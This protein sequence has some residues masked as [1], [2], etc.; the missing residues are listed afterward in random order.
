MRRL[1]ALSLLLSILL[2]LLAGCA[3]QE[4]EEYV[5]TGDAILM[6]NEEVT[7]A[8]DALEDETLVLA[9]Y[10]TRSMNPLIAMNFSNRVLFSLIYQGLFAYNSQNQTVPILCS[11]YRVSPDN[12]IYTFYVDPAATFSDGT[13]VTIGDVIASYD[14]ARES[15]YYKG[16]FTHIIEYK[17]REDGGLT[18]YLDTPYENLP[19][20]L[21][22][23][24]VKASEVASEHPLGTGPYEFHAGEDGADMT[25]VEHWWCNDKKVK[26]STRAKTIKVIEATSQSQ[27]RDEFEFG[28]LNLACADP[29]LDS[30]GEYRCDFELWE[31]DNGVMVYLAVNTLYSDYF[32]DSDVLRKA[33]TYAIDREGINE[34]NYRGMGQPS[35][36]ITSP[37]SPYYN[38]DLAK[39]YEY[40]PMRFL[41]AISSLKI[42]KNDK[43][44]VKKLRILVNADD[45]AR[46]RTARQIANHLTE[47]GIPAGVLEYGSTGGV[48]YRQIINAGN[49]D[50]YLGQTRLP[51]NYD[52]SEFFKGYGNLANRCLTNE[53]LLNMAQESLSNSGNFY[54]LN[55]MVA[56]DGS[57]I[58]ILF[59]TYNIYS[60]RGELLDLNPARDNVFYYT[61]GKTMDSILEESQTNE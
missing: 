43:N 33:L 40:D 27:L 49:Y 28:D 52:V 51:P 58:P 14:A 4:E 38:A 35:T 42:P 50:L 25:R 57:V 41:D 6:E 5:P 36:L 39:K 32:K 59:G 1:L 21:D 8:V 54:N 11:K 48:T 44:E 31:V 26:L 3:S 56:E 18:F 10:P 53:T 24:I 13:R 29:L 37:S 46:L 2:G 9:Y 55:Q 34:D 30:Y 17:L 19:L 16:R 47:L 15:D 7:E 60:K 23:P 12:M 20:L 45:S 61:I 22:I